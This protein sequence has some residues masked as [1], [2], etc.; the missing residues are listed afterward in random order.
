MPALPSSH[1]GGHDPR[2]LRSFPSLTMPRTLKLCFVSGPL[3]LACSRPPLNPRYA[4]VEETR[5]REAAPRKTGDT[6][7]PGADAVNAVRRRSLPNL[8][9]ISCPND[10]KL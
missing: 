5:H 8:D 9:G 1:N 7:A 2:Q 10:S 4:K 3:M 6:I